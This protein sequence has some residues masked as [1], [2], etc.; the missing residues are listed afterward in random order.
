MSETEHV[1]TDY[2]EQVHVRTD[3][4]I[5]S[6]QNDVRKIDSR[7]WGIVLGLLLNALGVIGVLVMMWMK[8]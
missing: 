2:C 1:R 6:V 7:L 5:D 8:K 3:G 4:W